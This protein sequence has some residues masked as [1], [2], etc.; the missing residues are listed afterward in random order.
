MESKQ[1]RILLRIIGPK[2]DSDQLLKTIKL[3]YGNSVFYHP[4]EPDRN[5]GLGMYRYYVTV[6]I[7]GGN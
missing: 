6:Q 5:Y 1:K 7:G 3:A 4:P 2:Q